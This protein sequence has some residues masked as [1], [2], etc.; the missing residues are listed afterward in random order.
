LRNA[1]HRAT[2]RV[3][4]CLRRDGECIAAILDY[5]YAPADNSF[6][7]RQIRP[8]VILRKKSQSNRGDRGAATQSVLMSVYRTLKLRGLNPTKT[9]ADALGTCPMTGRSPVLPQWPSGISTPGVALA[10]PPRGRRDAAP[11]S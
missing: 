9:M 7:E 8:A 1:A 5:P 3:G 10:L 4:N 6:G 2:R 11:Q